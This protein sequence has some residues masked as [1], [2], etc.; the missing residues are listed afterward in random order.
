MMSHPHGEMRR[1]DRL[2]TDENVIN[3]ILSNNHLMHVALSENNIPFLVPL[4]YAW[5]NKALYFHSASNGTKI[6][7]LKNNPVVCFE[8]SDYQGIIPNEMACNFEA[9]HRTVIGLGKAEFITDIHEKISA[10][11][12]IVARFT[13]QKF[14]Y[15]SAQIAH[16]NIVKISIESMKCKQ[17]GFDEE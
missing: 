9:K 14:E 8:V 15:P 10:L 3:D 16:T 13:E 12:D 11:D 5:K 4:F 1:T 17:H 2:V 6:K 7:I